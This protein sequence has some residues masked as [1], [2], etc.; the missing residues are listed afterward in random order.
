VTPPFSLTR[1]ITAPRFEPL[2]ALLRQAIA[3]G[4]MPGCAFGALAGGKRVLLDALGHFTPETKSHEVAPSSIFDVASITKVAMT[5]AAAMLLFERG[6]LDLEA[7]IGAI[8][9]QFVANR[10]PTDPARAIRFKHLLAHNSGL[11]GY[12]EFFR[13]ATTRQQVIES[14]LR[15]DLEAPVG[16]R[17][18]YSDPGFILLGLALDELLGEP[19]EHFAEREI[20]APLAM[21]SCLFRPPEILRDMIVPTEIDINF[22]RRMIQG[23]VQDENASALG[24]VAGHAG[25]FAT[26]GDLLN[27]SAEI[28]SA[29]AGRGVLFS[30]ETIHCFAERQ[31][32]AGSSRA[33]GWDTPSAPSSSGQYFSSQSVGHLG[34]SGCSLWIDLEAG[35]S[36]VLLT[37]RTWPDRKEEK[38]RTVRPAFH[39]LLRQILAHPAA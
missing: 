9:P 10:P 34:F 8:L 37:N 6:K 28:L 13:T 39:D 4:A 15:L 7:E 5:T 22:R 33:L 35:I 32:P 17:A 36:I 27:F 12:V 19:L 14:C 26:V 23:E 1:A 2:Y 38:I 25:L 18:C 29:R 31:P 21:H 30:A 24:G 16:E 20:Y 11:P 3:E